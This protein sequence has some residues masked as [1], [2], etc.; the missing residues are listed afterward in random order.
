M[1]K[2]DDELAR[3]AQGGSLAAFEALVLRH[4]QRLLNYLSRISGNRHE[5]EDLAQQA[6]V[7]AYRKLGSYRMGR[8]FSAW[9]FAI[10]RHVAID[11]WRAR[12]VAESLDGEVEARGPSPAVEAERSDLWAI[13]RRELSEKQFSALWLMYAE[14]YTVPEIAATLGMTRISVRVS[15]HRA[16]RRLAAILEPGFARNRG[17]GR[18]PSCSSMVSG[19]GR[20]KS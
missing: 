5:A 8:P 12:K 14:G 11:G 4:E 20:V 19:V 1:E 3:A 16:R 7:L 17:W 9:L 10:G 18:E 2:S 6:F 15:V 13:A